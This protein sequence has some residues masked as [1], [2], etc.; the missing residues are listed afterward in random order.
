MYTFYESQVQR[1][2]L[3]EDDKAKS[4][5]C[6]SIIEDQAF[7]RRMICRPPPPPVDGDTGRLRKID[8]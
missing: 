1:R 4:I 7:S 6:T 2:H 5:W 3:L 8:N